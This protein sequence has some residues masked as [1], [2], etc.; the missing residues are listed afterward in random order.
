[1]NKERLKQDFYEA[2]N[3]EWQNSKIPADKPATGGFQDLVDGSTN[4]DG[5]NRR[6]ACPSRKSVFRKK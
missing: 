3:E 6:S 2:V 1:M 4:F 5:R